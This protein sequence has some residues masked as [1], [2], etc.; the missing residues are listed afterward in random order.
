[1]SA[2]ERRGMRTCAIHESYS[3]YASQVV[4]MCGGRAEV[5]GDLIFFMPADKADK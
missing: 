4:C 2:R 1:M 5:L 3:S